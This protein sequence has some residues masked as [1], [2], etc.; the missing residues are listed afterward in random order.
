[1]T[2][3][4]SDPDVAVV[5]ASNAALNGRDVD[6]MLAVYAH[7]AAVVDRRRVGFGS[8]SGVEELRGLYGGIIGSASEFTEDVDVLAADRG[9]VV[10]HCEVGAQLATDPNGSV[11][12][13]QYGF[14]I[15]VRDGR[16]ARVELFDD[17]RGALE[18]SGLDRDR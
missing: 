3:A 8:F 1:M 16:I 4:G 11:V 5:L 14:V 17:G 2:D 12:G 6:G 18:A 10:A 9:L 7:D 13:A 15:T